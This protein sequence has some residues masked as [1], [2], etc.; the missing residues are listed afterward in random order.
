MGVCRDTLLIRGCAVMEERSQEKM[1]EFAD[2]YSYGITIVVNVG[3]TLTLNV[4]S[5]V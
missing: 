1:Q 3:L 4:G 5:I 2:E